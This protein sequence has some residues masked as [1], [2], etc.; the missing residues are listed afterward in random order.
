MIEFLSVR[1][2][3]FF[4]RKKSCFCYFYF[5]FKSGEGV[6]YKQVNQYIQ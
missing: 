5:P 2:N 6:L 4:M 1:I 3:K